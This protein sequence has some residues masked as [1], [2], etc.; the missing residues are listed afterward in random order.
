MPE[1]IED[2]EAVRRSTPKTS[3]GDLEEPGTGFVARASAA[4]APIA[5]ERN[6][7]PG[8]A[9]W[10]RYVSLPLTYRSVPDIA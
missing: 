8:P 6:P 10:P 4:W 9:N 5:T 7:P 2:E 1:S 3:G